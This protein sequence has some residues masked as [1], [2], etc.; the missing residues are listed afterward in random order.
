MPRPIE[1]PRSGAMRSMAAVTCT[2][3]S[4]G[5]WIEKPLSLKAT[6]PIRTVGG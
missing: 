3:S 4:V 5:T 2:S 6:T 1:V